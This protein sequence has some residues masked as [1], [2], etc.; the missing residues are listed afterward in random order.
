[1]K[2]PNTEEI[3]N[4]ELVRLAEKLVFEKYISDQLKVDLILK[5]FPAA[6]ELYLNNCPEAPTA[7]DIISTAKKLKAYI[8][9]MD[10]DLSVLALTK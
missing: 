7:D 3:L 6:L 9:D 5:S 2:S 8:S 4:L 1:M 10:T